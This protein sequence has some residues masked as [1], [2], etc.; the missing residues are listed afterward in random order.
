MSQV[1]ISIALATFAGDA[2]RAN[3]PVFLIQTG[4]DAQ[5][6]PQFRV[7]DARDRLSNPHGPMYSRNNTLNTG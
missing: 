1:I 3:E 2:L 7:A 5:G 4:R 6:M